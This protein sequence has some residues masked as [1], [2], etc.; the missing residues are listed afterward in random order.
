MSAQECAQQIVGAMQR[1]QRLRITSARGRLGRWARLIA[2]AAV[3]RIA[4]RAIREH[5]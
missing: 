4:A 5:R 1:R 2:P 3:D